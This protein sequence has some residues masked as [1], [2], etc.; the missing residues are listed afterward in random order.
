MFVHTK[1]VDSLR[2]R[3]R[4]CLAHD[5][6]S[7]DW[8]FPSSQPLHLRSMGFSLYGLALP[9]LLKNLSIVCEASLPL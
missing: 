3:I 7:V 8:L 4:K 1:A 5:R 6:H 2:E 9:K